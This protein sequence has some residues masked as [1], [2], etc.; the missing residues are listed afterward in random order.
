MRKEIVLSVILILVGITACRLGTPAKE[1]DLYVAFFKR[2]GWVPKDVEPIIQNITIPPLAA[3]PRPGWEYIFQYEDYYDGPLLEVYLEASKDIGLDFTPYAGQELQR[4]LY[5][6]SEEPLAVAGV[7]LTDEE[8]VAGAWLVACGLVF[9]LNTTMEELV[10]NLTPPS[11]VH[12]KAEIEPGDPYAAFFQRYGWTPLA[13]MEVGRVTIPRPLDPDEPFNLFFEHSP[14]FSNYNIWSTEIGL[15][16]ISYAGQELEL[17][18]YLLSEEPLQV[19]GS[20]LTRGEE[21]VGAWETL[22]LGNVNFSLSLRYNEEKLALWFFP[23]G[24]PSK[25]EVE[26]S[27]PYVDLFK[28]HGWCPRA[29]LSVRSVTL[30]PHAAAPDMAYFE[31]EPGLNYN[32]LLEGSRRIGLDFISYAGR[33]LQE[34]TYLLS[35]D[36]LL[37]EGI[38]FTDEEEIVGAGL[39]FGGGIGIPLSTSLTEIEWLFFG[40]PA[41]LPA[42]PES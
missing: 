1:G 38:L 12:T 33:E 13:K 30:P 37:V 29:K 27:D 23:E 39:G 31:Y 19:T 28:R 11:V 21:I 3:T 8:D 35:G 26:P 16:F 24:I 42:K 14:D 25:V 41:A 18:T 36:P 5:L 32:A 6:L 15:D 40:G 7:L 2:Y 22:T 17:R 10:R 4:R 9:P 20:L 34:R